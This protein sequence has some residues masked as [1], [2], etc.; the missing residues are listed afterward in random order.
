MDSRLYVAHQLF[1]RIGYPLE[2]LKLSVK[3]KWSAVQTARA[4]HAKKIVIRLS[5]S[6]YLFE[7]IVSCLSGSS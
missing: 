3:K 1:K 6:G 2:W 4:V 5:G 7:K